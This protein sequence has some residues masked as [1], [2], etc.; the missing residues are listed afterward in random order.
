MVERRKEARRDKR[1]SYEP[2]YDDI[3]ARSMVNDYWHDVKTWHRGLH[4]Q[5]F[6]NIAFLAGYQYHYWSEHYGGLVYNSSSPRWRV[7]QPFNKIIEYVET[8]QS[9]LM[10]FQPEMRVRPKTPGES[11]IRASM[12]GDSLIK[13]YWEEQEMDRLAHDFIRWLV[14]TGNAFLKTTWDAT[15]GEMIDLPMVDDD[16]QQ[17]YDEFGEPMTEAIPSGDVDTEVISPFQIYLPRVSTWKDVDR[18]LQVTL[19]PMSWVWKHLPDVAEYVEESASTTV[20]SEDHNYERSLLNL[21]GPG[22]FHFGGTEDSSRE[23]KAIVKEYWSKPGSDPDWEQGRYVMAVENVVAANRENTYGDLPIQHVGDLIVP[24]RIWH[25]SIVEHLIPEQR[26]FNRAV[27]KFMECLVLHAQP[28]IVVP[29]M[30]GV[31]ESS[32][33]TEPGERVEYNGQVPPG[34]LNPP[35]F[36]QEAYNW[37]LTVTERAMD[38]T[39]V[40]FSASRGMASQRLSGIALAQL[41]E[42]DVRDM[43]PVSRRLA[44]GYRRWAQ[45]VLG[46]IGDYV[47]EERM[48]RL[49]GRNKRWEIQAWTGADLRNHKDVYVDPSSAMPK[50]KALALTWVKELVS[51]GIKNP[52]D[53]HDRAWIHKFLQIED[54][55]LDPD[56]GEVDERLARQEVEAAKNGFPIPPAK[57]HENHAVHIAIKRQALQTDAFRDNPTSTQILEQHLLTHYAFM[58]PQYGQQS[59]FYQQEQQGGPERG[60][61]SP[62]PGEANPAGGTPGAAPAPGPAGPMPTGPGAEFAQF[63]S[64]LNR[65]G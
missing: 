64:S 16:G 23:P 33:T 65:P 37:L 5:W 8:R 49:M 63:V 11:D 54:L 50:N 28:K 31:P 22:G 12:L 35:S 46:L 10:T 13:S 6:I 17:L 48:L 52:M 57:W 27:G 19:R 39:S 18:F 53:P 30:A 56:M 55:S 43:T 59:P 45:S 29:T 1:S 44:D 60:N 14:V 42:Q 20:D 34:Y 58:M 2:S 51:S 21:V 24:G 61:G 40:S 7:R 38:H 62:A 25:Q 9:T 26:V 32:L 3:M 36:A 41:I 15:K 47:S 4:K